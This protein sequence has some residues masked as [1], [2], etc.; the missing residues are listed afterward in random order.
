MLSKCSK[1]RFWGKFLEFS[2]NILRI[3][4]TSVQKT[5]QE[6]LT[7]PP[8]KPSENHLQFGSGKNMVKFD[9]QP[10]PNERPTRTFYHQKSAFADAGKRN[11][12]V[13]RK[14]DRKRDDKW[15]ERKRKEEEKQQA[16]VL[17]ALKQRDEIA[18]A[19]IATS[20]AL[21]VLTM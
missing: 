1:N 13:R 3:I 11:K 18:L 2:A 21:S 4:P 19:A 10:T 15:F 9:T 14:T 20:V 12:R 16:A 8:T 17:A 6:L 5:V 7:I